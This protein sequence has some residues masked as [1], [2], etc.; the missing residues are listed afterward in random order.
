MKAYGAWVLESSQRNNPR[1]CIKQLELSQ[2]PLVF[3]I[4]GYAKKEK[5][6]LLSK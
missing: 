1:V 2:L 6:S 3:I 4:P 5:I